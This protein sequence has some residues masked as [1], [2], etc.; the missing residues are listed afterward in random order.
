TYYR[1]YKQGTTPPS[2][3]TFNVS[4]QSNCT[5]GYNASTNTISTF[6]SGGSCISGQTQGTN[7]SNLANC[8][9]S[10]R[11]Q[12]PI[13]ASNILPTSFTSADAGTWQVDYYNE[14]DLVNCAGTTSVESDPATAPTTYYSAT[15]TVT[16]MQ[17]SSS[18]APCYT[19]A[20]PII[21]KSFDVTLKNNIA[22]LDWTT[23]SEVNS[24][25]FN[26]ERS[27][28]QR[29]WQTIGI[30]NAKGHSENTA[31]YTFKDV[32]PLKGIGYY[33]LKMADTNGNYDYSP[34]KSVNL[35]TGIHLFVYPNPTSHTLQVTFNT[36]TNNDVVFNI[37]N[38]NGQLVKSISQ[39][40]VEG[41][42]YASV[43]VS[44]LTDGLYIIRLTDNNGRELA[45][46][47]FLKK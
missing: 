6:T 31:Y 19:S 25:Y 33:R 10:E 37:H 11:W 18:G 41:A 46:A 24:A 20:L 23:S 14:C 44:D 8:I 12:A 36:A 47:S 15:F 43:E 28:D 13:G 4:W 42:N 32:T 5:G 3:T 30:V 34:I 9:A 45:Q 26:I 7:N 39:T 40:A 22:T 35:S 29:S 27:N 38:T 1:V 21:L 17:G 16:A 2:F